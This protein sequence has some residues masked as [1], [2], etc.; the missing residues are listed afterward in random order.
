MDLS[1]SF[2]WLV[3]LQGM[4][5][6]TL[7]TAV[8]AIAVVL[9]FI[10]RLGLEWEMVYSIARAFL[11][12]SI[13]GFVLEF[14]FSRKNAGWIVLAYL[15]MVIVAGYTAGQRAKHVPH[16]KYIAGASILVGTTLTMFILVML[17][18]F[19]FTPRYIIPV[20]GM[21]VGNAMTVTGVTMK[22]LRE[23]LKM[24]KDLVE[25]A[26]ALGATPRQATVQQVKRSLIIA[27]SPV[28]DNAKTVGLISLPGAMTGLIMAGAPPMEAIQLQIVVMNM[29]VGA[30][31]VSSIMSTYL[32]WPAFFTKAH[33]LEYEV[34]NAS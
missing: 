29:L 34:F 16:G 21:M 13:M 14:V 25:T 30:S 4:L 8:L 33:Q 10:Q 27:L 6:P 5:K 1:Q 20:S 19:P 3:Y 31:T 11:Q 18:V 7:A 12:L 24:Q 9:S 23:D 15:F 2:L 17:N 22:K 32:C 26:L 28:L